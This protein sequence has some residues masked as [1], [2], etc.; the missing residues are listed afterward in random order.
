MRG[1]V[2][3]V[4]PELVMQG[5]KL[6]VGPKLCVSFVQILEEA[7]EEET[8]LHNRLMPTVVR[9]PKQLLPQ[10]KPVTNEEMVRKWAG[11]GFILLLG[12]VPH[13]RP[14]AAA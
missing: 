7:T 1:L 10:P 12:A 5:L 13:P 4:S 6:H 2:P 3:G 8:A 11:D 9:P 14:F